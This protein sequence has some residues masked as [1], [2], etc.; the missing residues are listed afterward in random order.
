[1]KSNHTPPQ[2]IEAE[3]SVLGGLMLDNQRWDQ[4]ADRVSPD[5]FY[6]KEHRL[7]FRAVASLCDASGPA[8]V[9]TVSE[10]LEKNGELEAAGGLSY[11]GQLANNTPS[12]ANIV[13]YA[14]IVRERAILRNLIRIANNIGNSAYNPEGRNAAEL[15]DYA[16]KHILDISEATGQRNAATRSADAVA[17]ALDM[18]ERRARGEI[19]PLATGLLDLD[20]ALGGGL[21]RGDLIIVAG[22]PSMGKTSLGEQLAERTAASGGKVLYITLEMS[23]RGLAER[24]LARRTGITVPQMRQAQKLTGEQWS[25]LAAASGE[26]RVLPIVY[27]ESARTAGATLRAAR[28]A[29][30]DGELAAVIIDYLQLMSGGEGDETRATEIAGITRSL[31]S[32]AKEI[33]V[34]V[35]TLSQLNRNLEQRPNRR[36]VMSDLRESGA[37]EQ[38]ADVILFIYRDEVY[39]EDSQ[40][41]GT[42]EIIIGKQRNGPTG[43]V[44]VAWLPE[45]MLF[46]DLARDWRP[47]DQSAKAA[48][49]KK[50]ARE[51]AG[52]R[53]YRAVKG[54][55]HAT[56]TACPF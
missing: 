45:R 35:V 3:Q 48:A 56:T 5:D 49:Q 41:K 7:I 28:A 44:R 25:G 17:A 52:A 15:L 11:L 33:N 16:E 22:R 46:A 23:A 30:R 27:D 26:I 18:I 13:A 10:W 50:G 6:R 55:A 19:R 40:D 32:L 8:D 38:D 4:V 29:A 21:E 12:A 9:V 14:D 34:P 1:M 54:G 53:R 43:K 51:S 37:I 31:K 39:N 36:P 47:A 42:A 24:A 2:S 20:E